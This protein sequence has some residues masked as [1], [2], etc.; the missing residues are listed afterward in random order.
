MP[1]HMDAHHAHWYVVVRDECGDILKHPDTVF[2]LSAFGIAF[3][4]KKFFAMKLIGQRQRA[5]TKKIESYL[6][7]GVFKVNGL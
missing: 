5:C 6:A 2:Q 7:E 3:A 1:D 4:M